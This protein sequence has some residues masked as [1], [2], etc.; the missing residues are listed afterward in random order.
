MTNYKMDLSDET[1][2]Q[3]QGGGHWYCAGFD[4]RIT[5][6]GTFQAIRMPS[7]DIE[8]KTLESAAEFAKAHAFSA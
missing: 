7:W 5:E 8:F 1:S 3:P 2:I 6:A 4:I